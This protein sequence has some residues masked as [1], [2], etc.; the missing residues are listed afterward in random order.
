MSRSHIAI[1][2][3]DITAE[4]FQQ[5]IERFDWDLSLVEELEGATV[6]PAD[7]PR[8]LVVD[9]QLEESRELC[10]S[11]RSAG[12]L[13]DVP[14]LAVI[15]DPWSPLVTDAFASGV[16]D[17]LPRGQLD[18]LEQ[19]VAAVAGGG[20]LLGQSA[21]GQVVLVDPDRDQRVLLARQLRRM[22][23]DVHF[24]LDVESI[25]EGDQVKM[26]VISAALD[27]GAALKQRD[28]AR[29]WLVVGDSKQLDGLDTTDSKRTKLFDTG[30]DPGQIV[31]VAN[32][33]LTEEFTQ[34]R[35][36]K[37]LVYGVP[38]LFGGVQNGAAGVRT[39][40]YTYNI[41]RGG[42]FVRTLTPPAM[43]TVLDLEFTPP[44]GRGRVLVTG[45]VVWRQEQP[46]GR[47]GVPCGFGLQYAEELPL[48]D[49]AA[50]ETGYQALS[51]R[52]ERLG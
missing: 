8:C 48:A 19:K 30:G 41:S 25:P 32:Q 37:R 5:L 39:Y 13:P 42:L 27:V 17:Y 44:T 45:R 36:S 46:V 52:L 9:W 23:F 40:G 2:G 6:A 14:V 20:A 24:A 21:S 35:A 7:A 15:D 34:L 51:E 47:N 16:D 1:G 38:I 4:P 18:R 49:G 10:R 28:D 50:L 3:L 12:T 43:G 26:V 22:G 29:P 11:L 33:L 31:F